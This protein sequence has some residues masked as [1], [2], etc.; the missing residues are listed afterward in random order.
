MKDLASGAEPSE[1]LQ[2]LS[3]ESGLPPAV[4][5]VGHMPDLGLLAEFW[6]NSPEMI[7]FSP[8]EWW[9]IEIDDFRKKGKGK[10]RF[11]YAPRNAG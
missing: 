11:S 4:A 6:L 5:L 10:K 9:L 2:A 7:R 3:R 1:I 8:G